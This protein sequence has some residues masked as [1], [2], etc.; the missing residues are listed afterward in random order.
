LSK[1]FPTLK[2]NTF[3]LLKALPH[4]KYWWETY[5]E[6]HFGDESAIFGPKPTWVDFVDALKEQYYPV[7]NYDDQYTRWR[8]L[9]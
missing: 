7:G 4:V 9:H 8:T 6:Q 5:C 3:V 2:K 1:K